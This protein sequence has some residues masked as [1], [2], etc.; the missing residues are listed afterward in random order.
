MT[1]YDIQ[2]L[3]DFGRTIER[4][5]VRHAPAMV[6]MEELA[7]MRFALVRIAFP[8]TPLDEV[9]R[10]VGSFTASRPGN[11]QRLNEVCAAMATCGLLWRREND[12]FINY[13]WTVSLSKVTLFNA[14]LWPLWAGKTPTPD[15]IQRRYDKIHRLLEQIRQEERNGQLPY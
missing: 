6:G 9:S 2:D 5:I 13:N 10:L 8:S 15:E 4:Q 7:L 1:S 14:L 12:F 3:V 11:V